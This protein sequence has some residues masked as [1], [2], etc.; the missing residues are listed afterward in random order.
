MTN[1]KGHFRGEWR[2]QSTQMPGQ[3]NR[4]V[5]RCAPLIGRECIS[6]VDLEIWINGGENVNLSRVIPSADQNF[7]HPPSGVGLPQGL[8]LG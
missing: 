2:L 4:A 6:V 1:D 7:D 3:E 5:V 8:P